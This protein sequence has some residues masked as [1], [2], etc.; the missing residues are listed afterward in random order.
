MFTR[1]TL[2]P[3]RRAGAAALLLALVGCA[4]RALSPDGPQP[5]PADRP[6]AQVATPGNCTS[7]AGLTA[8]AQ[9]AFRNG[10]PNVSAAVARV[11]QMERAFE[12]GDR[13]QLRRAG[14]DVIEFTIRKHRQRRL[15]GGQAAVDNF[16]RL[17]ACYAG[18]G[19]GGGT[20]IDVIDPGD[21]PQ[22]V[23][24][25]SQ[26]SAV[27][28]GGD[29][30]EQSSIVIIAPLQNGDGLQTRLDKYPS[31]VDVSLVRIADGTPGELR[32][33]TSAE[34]AICP[35]ITTLPP[36]TTLAA[37]A[38][39]L[40]V[41]H[42]RRPQSGGFTI[43]EPGAPIALPCEPSPV[44]SALPAALRA[45]GEF[46]LPARLEAAMFGGGVTG[47]VTEFSPFGIV[48]PEVQPAFGGGVTGTVTE[49]RADR[50]TP[51]V[52][53]SVAIAGPPPGCTT[54]PVDLAGTLV[55]A[56]CQPLVELRTAQGTVLRDV[57]ID[58]AIPQTA[59]NTGAA[60]ARASKSPGGPVTCG[61]FAQS[62]AA[63]SNAV[64]G[65]ASV[66]W[67]LGP[68]TDVTQDVV[69][70]PRIGG[71][72]PAGAVF[73]PASIGFRIVTSS[74]VQFGAP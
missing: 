74:A 71:D 70:T 19:I 12:R 26:Q 22:V 9:A 28:F 55:P 10:P 34:V 42:Q 51:L 72:M 47:T 46:L 66:C 58:F 38:A 33:G 65:A 60:I 20:V 53:L 68:T 11:R 17:V 13:R 4:D 63:T 48:D 27:R 7:I 57:P 41:G 23:L 73:A 52:N 62:V 14:A 31:F 64:S 54:V 44:A 35:R 6:M 25:P 37:L 56:E 36:G 45:V 24:G 3:S 32:P 8:A 61:A 39:R 59:A 2:V 50:V 15:P 69:A 18:F 30:V 49:F 16:T 40:R 43:T 21:A 5:P 1:P 67:R 29:P